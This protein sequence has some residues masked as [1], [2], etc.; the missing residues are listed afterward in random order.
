MVLVHAVNLVH[1]IWV[2]QN[3][4][5]NRPELEVGRQAQCLSDL[6]PDRSPSTYCPKEN[7]QAPSSFFFEFV[8]A[9]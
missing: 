5:K 9:C 8:A 6:Y 2:A 1:S 7:L 3:V 4:E